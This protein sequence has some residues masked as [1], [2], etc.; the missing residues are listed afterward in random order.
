M[1]MIFSLLL[2]CSTSLHAEDT[3]GPEK[4]TEP[5][6]WNEVRDVRDMIVEQKVIINMLM[7]ENSGNDACS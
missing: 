3:D 1:K 6:I 4:N 5:N 2:L 7:E